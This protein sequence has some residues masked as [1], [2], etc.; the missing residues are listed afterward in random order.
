M[1]KKIL[2]VDDEVQLRDMLKEELKDAGYEVD[3]AENGQ[4]GLSKLK[5]YK[6]DLIILDI[7]M[8]IMDGYEFFKELKKYQNTKISLY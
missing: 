3:T 5:E 6:P 7:K 8:P 1:K 4:A 2:I